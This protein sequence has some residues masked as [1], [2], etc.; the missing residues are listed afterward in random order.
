[1]DTNFAPAERVDRRAF[2]KQVE[3]ISKSPIMS[4]LLKATGGLLLILNEARQIVGLNEVFLESLGVGDAA[5]VLG[6]RLGE[7]LNCIHATEQP[8]GCGTTRACRTCGAA[9]AM[10][11]AINDDRVSEQTCALTSEKD[12]VVIE[13]Y[14]AVRAHP[15]EA[16]GSRWILIFA[17]DITHQ[18]FLSTLEHVFFHDINNILTALVGNSEILVKQMPDQHNAQQI[19]IAVERL[20][21]EFSLQK[22]LSTQKSDIKLLKLNL[23]DL[24]DIRNELEFIL[25]GHPNARGRSLKQQWPAA[26]NMISTDIHLAS[27]VLANMVLN[28]LEATSQDGSVRL[29]TIVDDKNVTWEVWNDTYIPEDVQLRI[30]QKH[31]STKAPMGRGMGTHSMKLLGEKLLKGKVSFH[32]SLDAGTTFRFQHP[33]PA[34]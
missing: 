27:R 6:L 25:D 29:L 5:D 28:A 2:L 31:F 14:L 13:R 9:I 34:Q 33:L 16:D 4:T 23:I 7:T 8:G 20:Y 1:M 21:S 12:G 19:R 32:S 17:Q 11:A 15:L 30:F 22:F 26:T 24:N 18:H 10:V 3:S